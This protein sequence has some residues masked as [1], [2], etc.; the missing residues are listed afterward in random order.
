MTFYYQWKDQLFA[1]GDAKQNICKSKVR[2]TTL[3]NSLK[4]P[5]TLIKQIFIL[6][7]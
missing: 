4:K 3:K 1:I 5:M 7:N 6:Y 2:S